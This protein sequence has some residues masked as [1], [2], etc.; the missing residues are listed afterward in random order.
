MKANKIKGDLIVL[1]P[2]TDIE[3]AVKGVLSRPE[4][5]GIRELDWR[6]II[7]IERDPGC[8]HNSHNILRIMVNNFKHS[9]VLMDWHGSGQE[10]KSRERIEEEVEQSLSFSGWSD[11]AKVIV[12]KPE[13]EVWIWSD[14]PEVAKCLGFPGNTP[15]LRGWLIERDLWGPS[16]PKPYDPKRAFRQTLRHINRKPS[17][18]IFEQLGRNVSFR[19]CTDPSFVKFK[20]VLQEWFVL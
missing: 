15:E 10:H 4:A 14:S 16:D 1:A 6:S 7:N 19:R 9:I 8:Y 5:L 20:S 17:P 12:I 13:V 2:D 3:F 11:R 18:A